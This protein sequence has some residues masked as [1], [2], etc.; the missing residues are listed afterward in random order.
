MFLNMIFFRFKFVN[1]LRIETWID[2][3]TGS[4]TA[5]FVASQVSFS[6]LYKTKDTSA[7]AVSPSKLEFFQDFI[8]SLKV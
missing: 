6:G 7:L 2:F 8:I 4:L 1:K 5:A 3:L